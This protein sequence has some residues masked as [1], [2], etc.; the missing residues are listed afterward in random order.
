MIPDFYL[1]FTLFK[2][3]IYQ[4]NTVNV[5]IRKYKN[6][7]L[8]GRWTLLSNTLIPIKFLYL[9]QKFEYFTGL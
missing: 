6:R 3:A 5:S 7:I 9:N 2:E 8:I 4:K 1:K